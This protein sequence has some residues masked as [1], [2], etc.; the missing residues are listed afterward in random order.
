MSGVFKE[1]LSVR[2]AGA[3]ESPEGRI[4][5]NPSAESHLPSGKAKAY[6]L[7]RRLT[8]Q[9]V[10]GNL[11]LAAGLALLA[12]LYFKS[13][14]AVYAILAGCLLVLAVNVFALRAI[15]RGLEPLR[16]LGERANAISGP[17]GEFRASSS[18]E[19]ASELMPIARSFESLLARTRLAIRRQRDFTSDA[20]HEMKTSVAIVKSSLQTLR[21]RPRT[22]REYEIGIDGVLEDCARLERLLE[23]MLRLSRIEQGAETGVRRKL[24]LADLNAS[25]EA[26]I[27]RIGKLAE[28]RGVALEF[29]ASNSTT[30]RADPEDLELVWTNLLEN[31]VHYS[32]PGSTVKLAISNPET[33][34]V[35]V[36]ILDSGPGIPA[37]EM[38]YIFERFHRGEPS[39]ART[40]GGFGLG[41]AICKAVVD[42][43]GGTIE[44]MNRPEGGAELRVRLPIPQ[45]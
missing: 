20:A 21:Y 9:I 17:H 38:P 36:S 5:A 2:S 3:V 30:L 34:A 32:P 45:A 15:R 7:K 14:T 24:G 26:S 8:A 39:A 28:E 40:D 13:L 12:A 37:V 10:I 31:A 11:A 33:S 44:A 27:E 19:S 1:T 25:C 23:R 43:C 42:S 22:Q 6:S 35:W 41:L 4:P 16:D 18:G 29:D